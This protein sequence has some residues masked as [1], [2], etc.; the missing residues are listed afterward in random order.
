MEEIVQPVV[1]CG[2][3]LRQGVAL[4]NPRQLTCN[5][6]H[7]LECLTGF[8]DDNNMLICPWEDCR[9]VCEMPLDKL[10]SYDVMKNKSRSCDV[11]LKKGEDEQHSFSY[12]VSCEKVFCVKHHELH[13]EFYEFEEPHSTVN[14]EQYELLKSQQSRVCAEHNNKPINMGCK[15][16]LKMVCLGCLASLGSCSDGDSHKLI[17]LEDLVALL[18]NEIN[19]LKKEMIKKEEGLEQIF[20]LTSQTVAEYDQE[21]TEM[22]QK[23]HEKRDEQMELLAL[24]YKQLEEDFKEARLKTKTRI[25]DF[26]ENEILV[27]WSQLR[28]LRRKVDSRVQH[29]H[30]CAIVS[31]YHELNSNIQQLVDEVLPSIDIP[32]LSKIRDKSGSFE[33]MLEVVSTD[34]LLIDDQLKIRPPKLLPKSIKMLHTVSLPASPSSTRVWNSE[35]VTGMYNKAVATIDN[36][37][38]LTGSLFTLDYFPGAIEVYKD[39][40]YTAIKSNPWTIYVHDRQGKLLTSWDHKEYMTNTWTTA[41]AITCDKVVAPDRKNKLLIIYSLTGNK[42]KDIP[43]PQLSR[44]RVSLCVSGSDKVV[45]SDYSSSQVC[46]IDIS[47]D[48]LLWTCKD[49]PQPMGI[50]CYGERYVLVAGFKS[51]TVRIL[52]SL[53]GKI[54]SELIDSAIESGYVFDMDI[55]EDRLIVANFEKMKITVFQLKQ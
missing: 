29:A 30:Q 35:I 2:F 10:P 16:C 45:V 4:I 18:N 54:V 21:T 42:L 20:K 40:L 28:N 19:K 8:Y 12:C 5:H 36:S 41:L 39:R 7:C 34:K 48:Q 26:S 3:C 33:I 27:K 11:C 17:S 51:S 9:V 13:K 50:A 44:N 38:Q 6:V 47:Q 31:G 1:E 14:M 24:K 23:I 32:S 15:K 55:S 49:V 53:T 43:C 52:D 22:V 46:L 25:T 37:Y